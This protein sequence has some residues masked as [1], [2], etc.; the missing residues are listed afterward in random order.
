[1]KRALACA[2]PLAALGAPAAADTVRGEWRGE[3]GPIFYIDEFGAGWG[4]HSTCEAAPIALEEGDAYVTDLTCYTTH[5]TGDT[6]TDGVTQLN[7]EVTKIV[8]LLLPDGRLALYLDDDLGTES[9]LDATNHPMK[10][11]SPWLT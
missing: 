4:D 3:Q 6:P 8:A 1:M 9:F 7:S 5:F 2:I 10:E 11:I